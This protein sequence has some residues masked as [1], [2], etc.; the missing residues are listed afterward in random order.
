MAGPGGA[1]AA[2]QAAEGAEGP[3]GRSSI[4]RGRGPGRAGEDLAAEFYLSRCAIGFV[5]FVFLA[6]LSL[7]MV[8][9]LK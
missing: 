3:D 4:R 2:D 1:Q 8:W 5:A 9:I 6:L 7:A